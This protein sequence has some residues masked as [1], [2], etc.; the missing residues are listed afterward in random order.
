MRHNSP[1]S[2]GL[3]T[4]L[5]ASVF[6]SSSAIFIRYATE[7][8]AISLTFFRL[9]IATAGIAVFALFGHKLTSLKRRDLLLVALSGTVLSLHF[10]TFILAVKETTVANATF[11]VNTSPIMLAVMSPLTIKERT[12]SR[13]VIAVL[14]ATLG[15]LLVANAG[16]GFREF[17]WGDLSALLA[18]FFVAIYTQVGRYLRTSGIN[19]ACYTSYVYAAATLVSLGMVAFSPTQTFKPYDTQN[20]LA[21][22]GLGFV[23]T[24]LGHTLYNSALGSVKT[25]TANLFP[26]MEPVVASLFAVVLFGEIPTIVQVAGYFLI[27]VGVAIVAMAFSGSERDAVY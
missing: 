19:T 3:L 23:P 20:T 13:E 12:T 6:F 8:S 15:I 22:L 25:V 24:M 11:L 21:I 5:V 1:S 16:N 9:F 26:L 7:A 17:G 27:L 14:V 4:L 2:T 18:A 10:A